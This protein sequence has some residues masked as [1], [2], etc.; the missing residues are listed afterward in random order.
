[1]K[2]NSKG[3]V[4]LHRTIND[5]EWSND[6]VTVYLFVKL[7]TTVRYNSAVIDG[8]NVPAGA[9]LFTIRQLAE[10]VE[11]SVKNVRTALKH[12]EKSE[13]IKTRFIPSKKVSLLWF[14][15]FAKYQDRSNCNEK[16]EN[17]DNKG[18]TAIPRDL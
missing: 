14:I 3:F 18:K 17:A 4:S 8:V 6:P 7:I 10:E 15:N 1:M 5:Q 13:T 9:R 11:L 2:K 16:P 12:L